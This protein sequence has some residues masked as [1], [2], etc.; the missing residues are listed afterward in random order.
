[1]HAGTRV[2]LIGDSITTQAWGGT[3][4]AAQQSGQAIGGVPYPVACDDPPHY[5]TEEGFPDPGCQSFSTCDGQATVAWLRNDFLD[6]T[7]SKRQFIPLAG[8]MQPLGNLLTCVQPTHVIIN[9]GAHYGPDRAFVIAL[10]R[11]ISVLRKA[12]PAAQLLLRTTPHGHVHCEQ[13]HVP[14]SALPQDYAGYLASLPYGWGEFPRQNELMRRVAAWHGVPVIDYAGP[15]ALRPD[16]E[17]GPTDCLH[18]GGPGSPVRTYARLNAGAA[19][20]MPF[21]R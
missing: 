1:M 2:L 5:G 8:R 10:D 17:R 12:A 19:R 18:Y 21:A 9:R 11:A 20:L 16:H 4:L 15:A 7:S 6:L 3:L 14:W 13:H